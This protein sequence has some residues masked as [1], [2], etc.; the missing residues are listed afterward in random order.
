V[1]FLLDNVK[2]LTKIDLREIEKAAK[3][4]GWQVGRTMKG[5]LRYVPPDP[6]RRIVIGSGT[7]SDSR[8]MKNFLAELKRQGFIW[9]WPPE[10]K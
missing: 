4:Q 7:P 1:I 3:E 10:G 6:T 9:P 8:A 2:E 5:H